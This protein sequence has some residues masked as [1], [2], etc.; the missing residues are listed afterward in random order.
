MERK[1]VEGSIDRAMKPTKGLKELPLARQTREMALAPEHG[2][3]L[4]IGDCEVT[5]V[6][7]AAVVGDRGN[8]RALLQGPMRAGVLV[9]CLNEVWYVE[10]EPTGEDSFGLTLYAP[11]TGMRGWQSRK[12]VMSGQG[13]VVTQSDGREGIQFEMKTVFPRVRT[14]P[15][16]DSASVSGG[17][18]GGSGG[19]SWEV[20][21]EY[22]VTF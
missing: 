7:N 5:F 18:S 9:N 22:K 1:T 15:R 17:T 6:P 10:S 4:A 14:S 13:K 12:P 20:K 19:T 3:V 21:G 11:Q 8:P 16:E 2:F